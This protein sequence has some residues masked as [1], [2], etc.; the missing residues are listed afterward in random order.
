MLIIRRAALVVCFA[1]LSTEGA[2]AAHVG[3][4]SGEPMLHADGAAV[5]DIF[6]SSISSLP[7]APDAAAI[8]EMHRSS[9]PIGF[10]RNTALKL[11]T[12][13][14][15][16]WAL[17]TSVG[18][19]GLGF[20]VATSLRTKINLRVG[21]SLLNYSPTIVE[22]GI[23]IDGRVRLRSANLGVDIFPYRSSFHITPGFTAYNGNRMTA[24]TNIVPGST[25]TINDTAYQSDP[26]DPVHGW[27]DVSL[28]RRIAPS[29]TI[30]WGNMLK[31]S[32]NW[33]MQT[34]FG[35]QYVTTPKF[36]L[37]MT[38]SVCTPQDGCTRIQD[39][40]STVA[41]LA[42]QQSDVNND[43]QVLRF[44]PILQTSISY[45]FGHKT[46]MGFWR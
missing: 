21:G 33:T 4:G 2:F 5:P 8:E 16:Q 37:V 18:I 26:T 29:L 12:E 35:I 39:D 25:F 13:A 23:P 3:D 32:K 41:N 34:D 15:S 43:I 42:Q 31:R 38:G 10:G 17:G 20:Q 28:G 40:P 30:G 14:F 19:G 36:T 27:F 46:D 22:Q 11:H 9:Q 24:T 7:D 6:S 1:L 44:Y 45:R